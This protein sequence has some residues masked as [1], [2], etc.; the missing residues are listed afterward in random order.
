MDDGT[1]DGR[2]GGAGTGGDGGT[3]GR[4]RH[5]GHGGT[6][7]G[8]TDGIKDGIKDGL[9]RRIWG[10]RSSV[11]KIDAYSRFSLCLVPWVFYVGWALPILL[12]DPPVRP[13][14]VALSVAL[15][16]IGVWLCLATRP[17]LLGSLNRYLGKG[18][19]STRSLT[20][21]L[22]LTGLMLAIAEALVVRGGIV[23]GGH[24]TIVIF[25]FFPVSAVYSLRLTTSRFV[26]VL[27]GTVT[28]CA[29]VFLIPDPAGDTSGTLAGVA[30]FTGLLGLAST[31]PCAWSLAATWEVERARETEARLAVAEERLRFGRDLHDVLGRNLAVI[32]LKSEL[33]VQLARRGKP[34][35]AEQ[36]VEVQRI[37]R[38]SQ[39]EVREVVRGY[40]GIDLGAELLGARSVLEAA[41]ITCESAASATEDLPAPVQTALAWV[42]REA[43]TNVLRHG[44]ARHCAITLA[45]S[46]TGTSLTVENDGVPDSAAPSGTGSGLAGLR[47]RLGTVSGTLEAAPAGPGRFRLCA[48]VPKVLPEARNAPAGDVPAGDV[49]AGSGRRPA[50]PGPT[51]GGGGGPE[52]VAGPSPAPSP[53][54]GAGPALPAGPTAGHGPMPV[55]RPTT[56]DGPGSLLGTAV[57]SGGD[58]PPPVP[59]TATGDSPAPHAGTAAGEGAAPETGTAAG[60]GAAPHAGTVAGDG[61]TPG[62]GPATGHRRMPVSGPAVGSG[63]TSVHGPATSDSPASDAGTAKG[64]GPA[65]HAATTTGDGPAPGPGPA[66]GHDRAPDAGPAADGGPAP[67]A[68]PANGRRPAPE[69]R[70]AADGDPALVAG[71]TT[72]HRPAPE[73]GPAAG[74]SPAPVAGPSSDRD[75]MPSPGRATVPGPA[76]GSGAGRRRSSWLRSGACVHPGPVT[77]SDTE[78]ASFRNAPDTAAVAVTSGATG[79]RGMPVPH[80]PTAADHPPSASSASAS[81]A[82]DPSSRSL[83]PPR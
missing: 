68:G 38:E 70:V 44:D 11:Q 26:L 60:E 79:S 76:A 41:G 73:T 24:A 49:R 15:G 75:S 71:A 29:L 78:A 69:P 66:A 77:D 80:A 67:V 14:D 50:V 52:R 39:R 8:L 3:G 74:P 6:R 61:P 56:G 55:R 36:M 62:P 7:D 17:A 19:C 51:G 12:I 46:R 10:S 33:A 25:A 63:P 9:R 58:G 64:D 42:V 22:V 31:R 54:A 18:D 53:T 28:G 1:R 5:G 65:P 13:V 83:P 23:A 43:A 32:A 57:A 16:L 82:P 20:L 34:E 35:A 45:T 30:I 48:H 72:G 40:R 21:L 27:L 37:A 81:A 4:A 2:S 59:G 47:E